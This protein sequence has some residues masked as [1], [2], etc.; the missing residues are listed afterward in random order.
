MYYW[1]MGWCNN[2]PPELFQHQLI[3]NC[4]PLSSES[5]K[6]KFN[7]SRQVVKIIV[8]AKGWLESPGR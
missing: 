1:V 7:E 4:G 2:E 5:F 6:E 3:T 8:E